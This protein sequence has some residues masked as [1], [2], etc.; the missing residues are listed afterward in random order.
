ME[1][2]FKKISEKWKLRIQGE[3]LSEDELKHLAELDMASE[4]MER[5]ERQLTR[6]SVD[7]GW[8]LI[9]AFIDSQI[10]VWRDKL[11]KGPDEEVRANIKAYK[12]LKSFVH[13]KVRRPDLK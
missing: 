10:E 11:E 9:E 13:S 1:K 6:L 4:A 12:K 7:P 3:E 2:F 8:K 5:Q